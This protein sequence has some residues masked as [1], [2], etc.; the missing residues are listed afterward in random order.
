M[1]VFRLMG[2]PD[3][4]IAFDELPESLTKGF[5]LCRADGFPRH[6]KEW[7]GKMKR[8]TQI[9]PEK[10]LLTGQVRRFDPIV[11]E[12]SFF[13]LVDWTINSNEE[14][15]KEISSYVRQNVSKDFRLA[16]KLEEMALALADNK[17][18]GVML[19]PEQVVIIPL[20]KGEQAAAPSSKNEP[21]DVTKCPEEGCKAEFEGKYAKNALRM[22]TQKKHKKEV[23]IA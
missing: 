19:E 3:K 9:P 23:A 14:K 11:E 10:D 21:V 13:F 2:M 20:P 5:E 7:M 4:I 12:D 16:D 17:N 22:H 6:W 18:D 1:Q 8:I 15:W